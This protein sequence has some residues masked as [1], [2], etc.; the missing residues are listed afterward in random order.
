M[1]KKAKMFNG[2]ACEVW[3]TG[4]ERVF[5]ITVKE[6]ARALNVERNTVQTYLSQMS[7]EIRDGVEKGVEKLDTPGGTQSFRVIYASGVAKLLA[8]IPCRTGMEFR[9]WVASIATAHMKSSMNDEELLYFIQQKAIESEGHHTKKIAEIED[10]IGQCVSKEELKEMK[11]LLRYHH[12]ELE[13]GRR[14]YNHDMGYLHDMFHSKSQNV[15]PQTPLPQN[16][17]NLRAI[18]N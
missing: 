17:P 8:R 13:R 18:N 3:E 4:D 2:R 14:Q 9:S 6:L 1:S 11:S 10:K 15:L 5:F 12:Q 7:K 16:P